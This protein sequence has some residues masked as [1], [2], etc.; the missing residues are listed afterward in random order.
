VGDDL[1][2]ENSATHRFLRKWRTPPVEYRPMPFAILNDEYEPGR[3][4][5]QLTQF[6]E[7]LA[8]AG[9]GG[10]YLHAR[11]GLI[12][13]YLS[14]RWFELIRHCI[15]ECRRCGLV[16]Q[17]YDENSY[18]S[19][20][21]GGH[22]PALVP[23]A[24]SRY[25][26]FVRGTGSR[27]L[28]GFF[29]SLHLWEDGTPGTLLERSQI[30]AET[31]WIA[32]LLQDMAPSAWH[33]ETVYPSL[34]DPRTTEAFLATTHDRYRRELGDLWKYTPSIFTDEPHLPGAG[35]GPWSAGLHLTPYVLGQFQQRLGYDLAPHVASLFFNVGDFCAIRSDFYNLCH[36]LWM[37]NWALPLEKWCQD[38]EIKLTGHYLEHDWPCPYATPGHVH[39]LAHMD[40]PGSDMLMGFLLKGHDFFEIQGFEPSPAGQE[41]HGLYFLRQIHSIA[42]QLGKERVINE[43]WGAAGGES[44]PEDWMRIGRWLIV[45]GVNLLVPHSS[46]DTIRGGRKADHPQNFAP[47]SAWFEYLRPLND[48]LAR[49]CWISNQGQCVNRVLI[50]DP[51]T[52]AFCVSRKAESSEPAAIDALNNALTT[53][54]EAALPSIRH[55]KKST[56]SFALALSEAQIDYDIGD[57][58]VI[59][60]FGRST[61][62]GLAIGA[63]E[64]GLIVLPP[65]LQN[66]RA[67]TVERLRAF[68][69]NGGRLLLLETPDILVDGRRVDVM[70]NFSNQFV[71]QIEL[72]SEPAELM[73][74]I[75][76]LVPPRLALPETAQTLGL[77]HMHRQIEDGEIFYI[78]NSSPNSFRSQAH[79]RTDQKSLVVLDAKTGSVQ[80]FVNRKTP[81]GFEISLEIPAH[82]AVI[83]LATEKMPAAI[84][85]SGIE[86]S[87]SKQGTVELL[88][89][90][91]KSANILAIDFC[92]LQINEKKYPPENVLAANRRYWNA[93]GFDTN[94]WNNVIQYRDQVLSRDRTMQSDSG[95]IVGYELRIESGTNLHEAR[96]VV[97]CPELWTVA[98]NGR[99]VHFDLG[100]TFRDP[101]FHG[102]AISEFLHVGTN[103]ITLAARPFS[104]RQEIDQIYILGDFACSPADQGFTLS[105]SRKLSWGNWKDQGLPFYDAEVSYKLRLPTGCAGLS[106]PRDI[107]G[108]ALI[109]VSQDGNEL[110]RTYESPWEILLPPLSSDVVEVGVIGLPINLYGPWHDPDHRWGVSSPYMW[111]GETVPTSPQ[112]GCSYG[113]RDL[114]LLQSPRCLMR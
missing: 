47:Q 3:G 59:E 58:Y 45:H 95:G 50:V 7:S 49:L 6:I 40:W 30:D 99:E 27:D 21:S 85:A 4:E 67:A 104:V 75:Q 109:V 42:N 57:E 82:G 34:L 33:G 26:S 97:E 73:Q 74:R 89:V 92:S 79:V 101:R 83:L 60:E 8:R 106:F 38:H 11:P 103:Q 17:L 53:S 90:N 44:A 5:R 112:P 39:L 80:K 54:T 24:R 87:G 9:Y 2:I 71:G 114:G 96:L 77:A 37:E 105:P 61:P 84:P 12:T 16:P 20:F 113:H 10:A 25:V 98:V 62:H 52:T 72:F 78:V 100:D 41:A 51:L 65:G 36:Q 70:T 68:L 28:P 1:T 32:F 64:Y 76:Q 69:Q 111:M 15:N 55:V 22:V 19:G 23:E 56:E 93:H 63:R 35:H 13:E 18:P 43:C 66:L 91:R 107:W 29:L 110:G 102:A 31:D 46:W 81:E 48:E 88:E 94:G 14:D 86:L 108:G